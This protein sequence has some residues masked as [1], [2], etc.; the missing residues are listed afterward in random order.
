LLESILN[1]E[2]R[3]I[4]LGWNLPLGGSLLLI[5]RKRSLVVPSES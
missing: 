3:F 5:A 2:Q 1:F 4:R